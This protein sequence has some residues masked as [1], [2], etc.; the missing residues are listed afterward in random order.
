MAEALLDKVLGKISPEEGDKAYEVIETSRAK[1][2][3]HK[4]MSRLFD[5]A[6]GII[7]KAATKRRHF[8]LVARMSL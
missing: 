5:F 7:E 8:T 4:H 6:A 2:L 1:D 3:E